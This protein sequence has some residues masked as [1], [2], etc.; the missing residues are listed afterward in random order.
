[1]KFLPNLDPLRFLL[2][3]LVLFGHVHALSRAMNLPF[4]SDL[5]I[6]NKGAEAVNVF[7]V[8]SGFLIIRII[9]L[10]KEK[11]SFSISVQKSES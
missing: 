2:A 6:F 5:P 9:Y 1:M 7:F 10:D 11:G 4:Y 3:S 8:L